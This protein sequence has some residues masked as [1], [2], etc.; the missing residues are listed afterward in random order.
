MRRA[1]ALF[2]FLLLLTAGASTA[3]AQY[4][5]RNK[6][7]YQAFDFQVLRTEHF[8]V[9]FYP[10]EEETARIVGR[11]A[12]R[13]H[14]RLATLLDHRLEGRQ[15]IILYAGHPD[16]EQTN[17]I[18][19]ELD[20]ATGGVTEALKRRVVIPAAGP[21][22]ETDHV[23][24]HELVHA[25]QYDVLGRAHRSALGLPLWF[26]EGM[27]EYL[28]LGPVD[29]HTAL[30]MRDA[31]RTGRLPRVRDLEDPRYFPYRYGHAFWAYVAGRWGDDAVG[32]ALHAV[33]R[34]RQ[35]V[36]RALPKAL[37]VSEPEL[38]R[39]WHAALRKAYASERR[40]EEPPGPG[41]VLV[42]G[43]SAGFLNLSPALSP[44][45]R[46][47][48]FLS[49][50]TEGTLELFLADATSGR[51]LRRIL[52]K[53]LDPHFD[54]LEFV[55]SAGA[56]DASGHRFAFAAVRRGHPVLSLF[57][58]DKG[59]I[60][61]EIALPELEEVLNP[62]W[63]PDGTKLAFSA[64]RAGLTDLFVYDLA[65]SRLEA[66]TDDAYADLQ[67]AWSPDGATI[68]FVTDRFSTRLDDLAWGEY[69]LASVSWPSRKIDALP[70]VVGS[71]NTNP[72]WGSRGRALY[73]LSDRSGSAEVYR[74]DWAAGGVRQVTE[75]AE[76][77]SGLTALSPALASAADGEGLVVSVFRRGRYHLHAL[78][79]PLVLAGQEL[80][81][82]DSVA[83]SA[84][85]PPRERTSDTV[86]TLL[87]DAGQGLPT[88]SSTPAEAYR[89]RLGFDRVSDPYLAVGLD[90][91]GAF[92]NGGASALWSDMLGN[93][94]LVTAVGVRGGIHD[95]AALGAYQNRKGR[96]V[97][98]LAAEQ[99]T[100][101]RAALSSGLT[102]VGGRP[103][104]IEQTVQFRETDRRVAGI[105][106]YPLGRSE[107]LE[108]S[109]GYRHAS[110]SNEVDT[111]T[112]S[113]DTG[114]GI[115]ER[116]SRLPDPGALDLG[117]LGG[118]FV[119]DSARFGPTSPIRGRRYR[120]ELLPT[121]GSRSF[122]GVL[123]DFR[124]YDEPAPRLTIASRLFHY[125]R[126]GRDADHRALAPLFLGY[127]NLVRGYDIGV[128]GT[129][130]CIPGSC[131]PID[132]LVGSKL[133]VG[134]LEVRAPAFLFASRDRP[135]GPVPLEAVLFFDAGV[136]WGAGQKPRFLGGDRDA[137]RSWGAAL[138]VNLL[139]FAI[140]EVEYIRPL[141][142]PGRSSLWRVRFSPGF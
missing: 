33:S 52:K 21:L 14:E 118:A 131:S 125:G 28:S 138:R 139:G 47:V 38:S 126:Y 3:R 102:E 117:E 25:F 37:G 44:D 68:A 62:T 80:P 55:Q 134:N 110:F 85:L 137:V 77:N 30:W 31:T 51:V 61:R 103:V 140:A 58:V 63:S 34:S 70:C 104:G 105:V 109:L 64:I 50:R 26:I 78:D 95:L 23:L 112:I 108:L 130:D 84:H 5:G 46:R 10:Q 136:A 83:D 60:V 32:R 16:F 57:D 17:A 107:R 49:E 141:D 142:L 41:R 120:V 53:R 122:T 73:F 74:L 19:G 69:R 128:Y 114:D 15:P 88:P 111:R 12:E 56:W 2:S 22:S 39:D 99:L 113:L 36:V 27:A 72:Q 42:S 4:F 89:S 65:A 92:V 54:S 98:T 59:E 115:G 87:D 106:A 1:V 6:V 127:P 90:R 81:V 93:Q 9:H 94:S 40:V 100:Y 86:A 45:G 97:W 96:L 133:L 11:L 7:R 121:F 20:E 123:A 129:G 67:P 79:E 18:P 48:V 82:T 101:R 124:R 13:W 71:T 29:A 66:L 75:G 91:F 119:H 116:K 8:D 132:P 76:G 35:S 24:G 135:Y 43:A